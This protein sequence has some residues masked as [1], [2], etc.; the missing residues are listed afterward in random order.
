VARGDRPDR[1][2][3]GLA[4]GGGV[5]QD[6]DAFPEVIRDDDIQLVL[7]IEIPEGQRVRGRPRQRS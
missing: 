7:D 2:A 1:L 4:S 6:T 3:A 5:Q